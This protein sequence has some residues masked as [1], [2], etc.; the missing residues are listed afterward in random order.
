MARGADGEGQGEVMHPGDPVGWPGMAALGAGFVLFLLALF[1]ARRRGEARPEG[2]GG[3]RVTRSWIGIAVQGFGI[4]LVSFGPQNVTLDP[5]SS[6]ALGEAA[7]IAVLMAA[8]VGL[9]FAASATMGR[10]WSLIA[11]TRSDHSLVTD[12]PFA[13]VRHPIYVALF[14]F[15]IAIAVAFGHTGRLVI[16]IPV[17][18]LGTWLRIS[19]EERL[20]RDMFGTAYDAYAARVK[21]FVPGIF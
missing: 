7:I 1:A 16:G 8:T 10:N 12:G 20:L 3:K 17:Y 13:Y 4:G 14:L 2:A 19:H 6:L 5:A 11:R 21:R 15:M 18:A 9:F